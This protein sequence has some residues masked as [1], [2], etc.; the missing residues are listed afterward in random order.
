MTVDPISKYGK[1]SYYENTKSLKS[2]MS[3][4]LFNKIS[5][6]PIFIISFVFLINNCQKIQY[7]YLDLKTNG[8]V[9]FCIVM[10]SFLKSAIFF[11]K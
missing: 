3:A 6:I 7:N 4:F 2:S 5:D 8:V 10:S 11:F 1:I 9:C